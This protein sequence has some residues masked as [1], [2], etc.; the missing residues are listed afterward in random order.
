[1]EN[2]HQVLADFSDHDLPIE[3][4]DLLSV[5]IND[6]LTSF[7]A[8]WLEKRIDGDGMP[9][10]EGVNRSGTEGNNNEIFDLILSLGKYVLLLEERTEAVHA[11]V[12]KLEL[13]SYEDI[14]A[15]VTYLAKISSDKPN[16]YNTGKVIINYATK[17]NPAEK[18]EMLEIFEKIKLN[19]YNNLVQREIINTRGAAKAFVKSIADAGGGSISLG[20]KTMKIASS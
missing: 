20:D 9:Y 19:I 2:E 5:E 17:L 14:I 18:R 4:F 13:W 8:G 1:M 3:C 7:T 11:R 16:K 10:T 12:K 15:K 6:E